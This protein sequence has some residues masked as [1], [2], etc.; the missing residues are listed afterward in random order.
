MRAAVLVNG[1][2]GQRAHT[3]LSTG[4]AIRRHDVVITRCRIIAVHPIAA[5][6][7]P[8]AG[9]T[10]G[11]YA[12][13]LCVDNF[14]GLIRSGNVKPVGWSFNSSIVSVAEAFLGIDRG[15][16]RAVRDLLDPYGNVRN[17]NAIILLPE[18]H[19]G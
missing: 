11:G 4:I 17:V 2:C 5:R 14:G 18:I 12:R 13:A 19:C 15:V 1:N 6:A 3:C 10:C 16:R 7:A 9:A 8:L